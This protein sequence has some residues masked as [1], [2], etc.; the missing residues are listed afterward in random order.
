[1]KTES[2]FIL[3]QSQEKLNEIFV[4]FE[5]KNEYNDANIVDP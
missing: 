3:A 5:P 1:M 2:K 4:D